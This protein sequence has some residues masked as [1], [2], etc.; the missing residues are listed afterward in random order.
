[1]DRFGIVIP[2]DKTIPQIMGGVLTTGGDYL[3][4]G[5]IGFAKAGGYGISKTGQFL[6]F[7][8]GRNKEDAEVSDYSKK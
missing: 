7:I 3:K 6:R 5:L 2:V 8:G 4:K 1:M